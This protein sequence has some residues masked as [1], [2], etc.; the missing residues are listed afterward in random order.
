MMNITEPPQHD[1]DSMIP[2]QQAPHSFVPFI[3]APSSIGSLTLTAPTTASMQGSRPSGDSSGDRR[4][5]GE[6]LTLFSMCG[7][8]D[9]EL[10]LDALE[11]R[12]HAQL[13]CYRHNHPCYGQG[14]NENCCSRYPPVVEIS[15]DLMLTAEFRASCAWLSRFDCHGC[16]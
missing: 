5:S 6:D 15:G 1:S 14:N 7:L 10:D 11:V 12:M 4:S 2:P 8:K 13:A 9:W 3:K 16:Q